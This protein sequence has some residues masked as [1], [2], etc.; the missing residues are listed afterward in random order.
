MQ[1]RA[2]TQ[3]NARCLQGGRHQAELGLTPTEHTTYCP[4]GRQRLYWSQFISGCS[5]GARQPS[6]RC[7][8]AVGLRR[9]CAGSAGCGALASRDP[10]RRSCRRKLGALTFAPHFGQD[11]REDR[12][13]VLRAVAPPDIC[14]CFRGQLLAFCSRKASSAIDRAALGL[15]PQAPICRRSKYFGSPCTCPHLAAQ[16]SNQSGRED[17]N[18]R[19]PLPPL[20]W[21][22]AQWTKACGVVWDTEFARWVR[23]ELSL[24][25]HPCSKL[26]NPSLSLARLPCLLVRAGAASLALR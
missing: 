14:R 17:S 7:R 6:Y 4:H 9:P 22:P 20:S 16:S 3:A 15:R 25:V 18:L 13:R 24:A 1:L 2:S 21:W 8:S 10:C 5:A 26:P 23:Q 12:G 11:A 19:P